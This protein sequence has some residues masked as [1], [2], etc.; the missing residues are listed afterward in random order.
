MKRYRAACAGVDSVRFWPVVPHSSGVPV[1]PRHNSCVVY[2]Q[3]RCIM[4]VGVTSQEFKRWL[5]KQGA[6]LS[7]VMVD[8]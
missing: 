4:R 1:R 6:R 8:T 2:K 3:D 5:A 7:L